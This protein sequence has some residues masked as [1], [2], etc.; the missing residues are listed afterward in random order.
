MIFEN[1]FNPIKIK[2]PVSRDEKGDE[3][4]KRVNVLD[5]LLP[6]KSKQQALEK[7]VVKLLLTIKDSGTDDVHSEYIQKFPELAEKYGVVE[8]VDD[9]AKTMWALLARLIPGQTTL[10]ST[11]KGQNLWF[12]ILFDGQ[13]C[14][15]TDVEEKAS[16]K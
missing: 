2:M 6:D 3:I 1:I 4:V 16:R 12:K 15:E 8:Q 14:S 9:L 5:D 7:D 10:L 11:I 13:D